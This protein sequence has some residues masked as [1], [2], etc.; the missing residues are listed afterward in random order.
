MYDWFLDVNACLYG[1][2]QGCEP[3]HAQ[4]NPV[5]KQV[6]IVNTALGS[7]NLIVKAQMY[8]RQGEKLWEKEA[9]SAIAPN[10]V[11]RLF[12]LLV[13]EKAEGVYF[14]RLSLTKEGKEL[15]R[16]IYWLTT[17]EKD[18]TTLTQ[19]PT[20]KP[21]AKLNLRKQGDTYKGTVTLKTR[22]RIS[23]FNRIKVFD[24]NTGK[25]I[26]PVHYSDN[27]ITLMPGDSREVALEFVSSLP[28][29]RIE[30]V[31]D[32]W[33]WERVKVAASK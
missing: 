23:F 13:P 29:D 28:E 9:S 19:L 11:L 17:R 18:Y 22:D 30:V 27:Y 5:S 24:K 1:A 20:C 16:R 4:Y 10:S 12:D 26:L 3:L 14:L 32:S 15:S 21:E 2:K 25:R 6:E 31:S 7:H 33:T 8:G